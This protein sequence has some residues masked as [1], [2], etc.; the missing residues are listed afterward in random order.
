[1][2]QGILAAKWLGLPVIVRGDSQLS[3]PRGRFKRWGKAI[4]YPVLLRVFDK[5]LYVGKNNHAYWRSYGFPESRLFFSPHC[6]ETERF[7]RDATIEA[8]MALR[9]RL[10]IAASSFVVLFAGKL[11]PF[12]R[13]LDVVRAIAVVRASGADCRLM[14]AGSGP[15]Q[16]ELIELASELNVPADLLGFQNQSQMPAAYAAADVLVLPSDARETWGLV[17]NEALASRLPIIVSDQVGCAPDLSADGIVGQIFRMGDIEALAEAI[18][19][20]PR[21]YYMK[22]EIKQLSERYSIAAAIRGIV[23]CLGSTSSNEQIK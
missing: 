14:V 16:A 1:M 19:S 3:T 12:K 17:A 10:N 8:R 6:V 7:E 21:S 18:K 11:L 2:I 4:A 20:T 15:L 22:Y 9:S 13:P 5:A 23:G